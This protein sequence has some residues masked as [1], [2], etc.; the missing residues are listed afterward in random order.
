MKR[1]VARGRSPRLVVRLPAIRENAAVVSDRFDGRV[2]GVTKAVTADR[3]V[4]NAMLS[5]GVDGFGDSRTRNLA[6]LAETFD[7]ERTLLRTPMISE[8]EA[9]V[10]V[11][12][13]SLQSEPT[14]V[15][16]ISAAATRQERVHE[17]VLM[18][19]TG[20]RRE[21]V[22]PENAVETLERVVDLPGIRVVG[23]GTNVGC[24]GGVVPTADSMRS[25]VEL[26]EQ[27]ESALGRRLPIVSGGSTVSL[28]LLERGRLPDRINELRVGEGI[29]LGTDVTG[30]R[31]VNGLRTDAFEL[32]AEVIE[33]KEKPSLPIGERGNDVTGERPTFEDRGR[34]RRAIV[35]MGNQDVV[36]DGLT[37]LEAG[38]SV[39][40][41]SGDHT[42]LDVTDAEREVG[43]GD[44][45]TFRPSYR[46]LVRASTSAY[47]TRAY[48][49]RDLEVGGSES[50]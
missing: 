27:A 19:D 7:L 26:V 46:A 20:D 14:V 34:R 49:G 24:F 2:L 3:N 11:A 5:G 22:L 38:V 18:V 31:E 50:A 42:V 37:P 1:P 39:L 4:A 32:R 12:N 29:L 47:V 41:T 36:A 33:C 45:V 30:G 44:T 16:A 43:V 35:A 17:I 9:V 21:G 13:R 15:E 48:R 8:V 40:G 6:T 10:A 23:L 25:F 28:A